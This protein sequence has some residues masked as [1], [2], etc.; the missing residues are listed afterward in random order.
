MAAPVGEEEGRGAGGAKGGGR[1]CVGRRRTARRVGR[2][3]AAFGRK[4]EE[5]AGGGGRSA[6]VSCEGLGGFVE[7][8]NAGKFHLTLGVNS[9]GATGSSPWAASVFLALYAASGFEKNRC[10]KP[11]I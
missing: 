1:R 11:L 3:E 7:W 10:E 9:G 2:R 4:M 8:Q 6:R 5:Q